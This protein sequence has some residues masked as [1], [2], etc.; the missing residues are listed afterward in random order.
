MKPIK[1]IFY[2]QSGFTMVEMIVVLFVISVVLMI[3][4]PDLRQAGV[5]AQLTTCEANQRLI[6]TQLENYYM[7]HQ[8]RYPLQ[9]QSSRSSDAILQQLEAEHYLQSVPVCPAG[10]TYDIQYGTDHV[11]VSCTVHNELGLEPE[12]EGGADEKQ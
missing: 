1:P 12:Q 8:Y 10:G 7:D 5:K 3:A 2:K 4:L 11:T 6:R 9:D